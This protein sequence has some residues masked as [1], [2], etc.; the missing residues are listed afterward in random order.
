MG[1]GAT[2]EA[3]KQPSS[4]KET[5]EAKQNAAREIP[6]KEVDVN[7]IPAP[8]LSINPTGTPSMTSQ[9]A[10]PEKNR[11]SITPAQAKTESSSPSMTTAQI[12]QRL[13]ELGYQPGSA[14]GKIGKSTIKALKKFQQDN[15]LPITGKADNETVNKL[16]QKTAKDN[17]EQDSSPRT[18]KTKAPG[19]AEPV[20]ARSPIDSIL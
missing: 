15:N 13:S 18:P 7:F 19:K 10:V 20:K 4:P 1:C 3:T 11:K 9:P 17:R 14:D 12:Q 16:R 8:R 2:H 5:E 6:A